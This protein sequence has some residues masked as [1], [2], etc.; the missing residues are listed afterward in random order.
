MTKEGERALLK[1]YLSTCGR[2]HAGF[3]ET[4]GL[5]EPL[6]PV[7]A[8]RID[9][10]PFPE[11]SHILAH[12]KRFEQLEDA[13]QRTLKAISR[14]MEHGRIERLTSVD[15]TRRAHAL[16]ILSSEEIW[17]DAVRTRNALAHEYPLNPARRAEQVNTAWMARETLL[18]TWTSIGRF[19]EE[20]GL[21]T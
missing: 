1:D 10:L 3:V 16:G 6:M 20:E 21:L 15:V 18:V 13:L 4:A 19:I 12:L 11:E 8:S 5:V 9:H 17:A 14:I 2:L 7:D